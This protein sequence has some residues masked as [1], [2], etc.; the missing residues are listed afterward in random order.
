MAGLRIFV[1]STCVDLDAQR[2]QVRSL[3]ERMGYEPVMSEY[4]DV[5]FDHRI[6]THTSCVKE[7]SNADMAILLIG[8]RFGGTIVPEALTDVD[9]EEIGK[10]S[11]KSDI[12][13]N[14][15]SNLS[16]TQVEVL[17]AIESDVPLF[18]FID[19][20]VHSDHHLYQKNKGKDFSD[21]II[22]PSIEKPETAKYIFEF[23][24][25]ITHRFSNNA[26][27]SYSNFS[28]IENHLIKQ[29][30][31]SFQRLLREERDKS[32]EA[33]RNDTLLEQIQDLKAAVLQSIS[34]G[35]GKEIAR[36]VLQYRRLIDFLIQMNSIGTKVNLSEFSGS[37][38]E[39]LSQFGI[40]EIIFS[41]AR[42]GTFTKTLLIRDGD[43]LRARI[44]D[45]RFIEFYREWENFSQLERDTKE[46]VLD[47]LEGN[48][49]IGMTM[50]THVN[51]NYDGEDFS[52]D[53]ADHSPLH[54]E[55]FWSDATIELLRE[56]WE[57]G[58]TASEIGDVLGVS[59]NAVIGKAHRLGLKSRPS[60]VKK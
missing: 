30:S 27:T 53:D 52:S 57:K 45:E 18:V 51:H 50:V 37:F 3:L 46:A 60:P 33:R 26:I 16:I 5:L 59:R 32:V 44:P 40:T 2:A 8:S 55:G 36:S 28:D 7:I 12:I 17:K 25:F 42:P 41:G 35:S 10:S 4:S 1:S 38:E 19:S 15:K 54:S 6:H 34:P 39:L 23:I 22:Y 13:L 14:N 9:I 31:M 49:A 11:N 48:E 56:L 47:G 21:K 20:K 29:W 24:N 43:Y 58:R